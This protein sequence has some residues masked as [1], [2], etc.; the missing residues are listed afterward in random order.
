MKMVECPFYHCSLVYLDKI[1]I[2]ILWR[3]SVS[4]KF[5]PV[6][7]V[8][9]YS[10]YIRPAILKQIKESWHHGVSSSWI[11]SEFTIYEYGLIWPEFSSIW[12]LVQ[13]QKCINIKKLGATWIFKDMDWMDS[14][15]VFF[16]QCNCSTWSCWTILTFQ[17]LCTCHLCK[18]FFCRII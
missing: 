3:V 5:K 10:E 11:I 14:C 9:R 18:K 16:N 6:L 4:S 17:P 12:E 1:S 8:P 13:S 15:K 7:M 2:A